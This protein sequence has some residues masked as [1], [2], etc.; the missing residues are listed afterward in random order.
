MLTVAMVCLVQG[1]GIA[2]WPAALLEALAVFVA[3]WK[4]STRGAV[5]G[6]VPKGRELHSHKHKRLN[7]AAL[8]RGRTGNAPNS[9]SN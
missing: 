2:A 9:N 1:T 6:G 8:G 4:S 5:M 3:V 7:Q